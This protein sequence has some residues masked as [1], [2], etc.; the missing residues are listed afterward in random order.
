[1][2]VFVVGSY[3]KPETVGVIVVGA[4]GEYVNPMT[5]GVTLGS[6]VMGAS[7]VCGRKKKKKLLKNRSSII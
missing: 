3:V 1:V 7:V 2:G 4:V 6:M 5:V